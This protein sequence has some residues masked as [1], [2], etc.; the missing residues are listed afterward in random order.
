MAVVQLM[1]FFTGPTSQ[2]VECTNEFSDLRSGRLKLAADG[3]VGLPVQESRRKLRAKTAPMHDSASLQALRYNPL[4]LDAHPPIPQFPHWSSSVPAVEMFPTVDLAAGGPSQELVG[5]EES[6]EE[7]G[8]N[9]HGVRLL[10][11]ARTVPDVPEPSEELV[12]VPHIRITLPSRLVTASSE[13]DLD[14]PEHQ[15]AHLESDTIAAFSTTTYVMRPVARSISPSNQTSVGDGVG[16]VTGTAADADQTASNGAQQVAPALQG[17]IEDV[18]DSTSAPNP[19]PRSV[20]A[21]APERPRPTFQSPRIVPSQPLRI[22]TANAQFLHKQVTVAQQQLSHVKLDKTRSVPVQ[23]ALAPVPT[24]LDD[25]LKAQPAV[26]NSLTSEYSKKKRTYKNAKPVIASHSRPTTRDQSSAPFDL[27][28]DG[29]I[30]KPMLHS[31]IGQSVE[32]SDDIPSNVGW[33]YC[34]AIPL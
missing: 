1:D 27:T 20:L 25:F 12:S 4:L 17:V 16:E 9:V 30:G 34:P 11:S 23:Q 26:R 33:D 8:F 31:I 21:V 2:D 28:L 22:S 14:M 18:I 19:N 15:S 13:A 6:A 29:I 24:P 3:S 7:D 10:G 32:L 5:G